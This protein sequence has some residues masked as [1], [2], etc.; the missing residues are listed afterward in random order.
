[1]NKTNLLPIVFKV[2][3]RIEVDKEIYTIQSLDKDGS[4]LNAISE[5]KVTYT[6]PSMT[7]MKV[8]KD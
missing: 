5:T 8:L 6:R 3:Q 7:Y 4:I 2:G 1:M